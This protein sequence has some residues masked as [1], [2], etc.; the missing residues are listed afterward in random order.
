MI[1]DVAV[2]VW[3]H[4]DGRENPVKILDEENFPLVEAQAI[5]LTLILNINNIELINS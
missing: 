2:L 1:P 3:W 5:L 4:S